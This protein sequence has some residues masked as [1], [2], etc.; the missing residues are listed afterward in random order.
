MLGFIAAACLALCGLPQAIQSIRDGHSN[1]ISDGFL[2]LWSAGEVLTLI[3]IWDNA[4]LLPLLMNYSS[5]ILFLSI[6]IFY[7]IFPR[8]SLPLK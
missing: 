6:I 5:N 1:G 7:K 2:I 8:K 3:Y 4:R